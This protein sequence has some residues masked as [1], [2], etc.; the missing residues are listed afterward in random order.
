M[1]RLITLMSLLVLVSC[2]QDS[3]NVKQIAN[4]KFFIE[5]QEQ[6]GINVVEKGLHYAVLNYGDMNSKSPE[7]SDTITAHFH[8]TLTDGTVFWSSVDS[9]EPLT[10]ELSK[11]IEGCQKIISLMKIN[12]KW[13]VYIDPSM[14]Y[15]DEGRPG[16][17]SNSI[18]IF[19][20]ELLDIQ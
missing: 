20:I 1:N 12:D 15:G 13:R 9:N 14:A 16:I 4:L 18:L 2:V 5:N 6:E 7:L 8:G 19:D 17:P 11:L 10:I 3:P